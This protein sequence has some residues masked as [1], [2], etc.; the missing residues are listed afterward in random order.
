MVDTIDY[1]VSTISLPT[2]GINAGCL[3]RTA[4]NS[5]NAAICCFS[6]PTITF[7][8]VMKGIINAH[9]SHHCINRWLQHKKYAF[10]VN[11]RQHEGDV[12]LP[13]FNNFCIF[14]IILF[15]SQQ[16]WTVIYRTS[17]QRIALSSRS[18]FVFAGF[19]V[20]DVHHLQ[21]I[22]TRV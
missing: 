8:L 6:S 15:E 7:A 17:A 12:H 3:V 1:T 13:C 10:H 16:Y 18:L 22:K 19:T 5:P 2:H 11:Y 9:N 20:V 14:L 4:R 21:R